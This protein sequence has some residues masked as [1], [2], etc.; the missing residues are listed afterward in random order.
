[1][2]LSH[3]HKLLVAAEEQPFGFLK[4]H[5]RQDDYEV[6]LMAEAGLIDATL[7]DGSEGCFTSINRV[8]KSGETF[9]RAF[10]RNPDCALTAWAPSALKRTANNL[11]AP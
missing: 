2:N 9:L 1:M 11:V 6:Q 10:K 5:G 3:V 7:Y 8:T 4:I